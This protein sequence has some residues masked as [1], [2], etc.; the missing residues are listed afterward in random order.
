MSVTSPLPETLSIAA[1]EEE[2][3]MAMPATLE[4]SAARAQRRTDFS[5]I[6]TDVHAYLGEGTLEKFLSP[7][8][9]QFCADHGRRNYDGSHYPRAL[10]HAARH[11]AWPPD[12]SLPGSNLA[13]MQEQ[14]LDAWDLEC[15]ILTPLTGAGEILNLDLGLAA[16]QA[17]NDWQIADWTSQDSRIKGSII[18]PY[19]DSELSAAEIH[20]M[21]PHPDMLQVLLITRT[22]EPL[23]QRRYWPLYEAAVEYD[24]PVAIHF[25]GTG[26]FPLTGA[27]WPSFYI[28]DHAGMA[29]S[30]QSQVT[31]LVSQGVFELYPDLKIVLIEGGFAWLAPL[32]WRLDATFEKLGHELTRVKERPSTYIRNHF[33]V[34]TQPIEEPLEPHQF[35][36]LLDYLGM[37]DRLMFATDY[38]HW[39][40]D[41]PDRA[42]PQTVSPADRRR[43]MAENARAL[44]KLPA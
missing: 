8:W 12:G 25:G 2:S 27:G 32:M 19:E 35:A 37:T 21:G 6:D 44:Y 30:F 1:V 22:R 26:G 42:L 10:P 29:Q 41:A 17:I 9:R 11:D 39:D 38:P 20:R 33:W 3:A 16:A 36:E 7:F 15:A 14:L 18:V 13:F 43:I 23:G 40:F 31:S 4:R 28:E 5:I 34:S 24:L